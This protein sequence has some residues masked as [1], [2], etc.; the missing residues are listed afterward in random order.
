MSRRGS[1]IRSNSYS[2]FRRNVVQ[3]GLA[4]AA[5]PALQSQFSSYLTTASAA[6]SDASRKGG[7]VL[8]SGLQHG[9]ETLR[10][11]FGVDVGDLGASYV[12]RSTGRGAGG[13]YGQVGTFD[14]PSAENVEEGAGGD[15][16][17]EQMGG[18]GRTMGAYRDTGVPPVVVTPAARS[19][20]GS[21]SSTPAVKPIKKDEWDDWKD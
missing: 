10:R 18:Q 8:A 4:R 1:L 3:P 7:E 16:F 20:V 14:A 9:G 19:V 15:F 11:D 5:D 2:P 17:G 12:E 21:R 6:L 13:G